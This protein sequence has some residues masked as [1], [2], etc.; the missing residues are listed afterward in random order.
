[1]LIDLV[2]AMR[3]DRREALKNKPRTRGNKNKIDELAEENHQN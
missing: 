2:R 3:R 1:M